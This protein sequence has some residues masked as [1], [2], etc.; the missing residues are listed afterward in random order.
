MTAAPIL[1]ATDLSARADRAI[2]RA[3]MLGQQLDRN[4]AVVYAQK[5]NDHHGEV[6]VENLVRAVLPQP[7]AD[8]RILSPTGTPPEEI[9]QAAKDTGAAIL[10]VGPARHNS[11]GDFFLGTAVDYIARFSDVPLLV[12]KK[13]AHN[14]Y[15]KI[16]FASDFS[17]CSRDALMIAA[18]LFP[19]TEIR[20]VH[21]YQVPFQSWQKA[22]YVREEVRN[23]AQEN[24]DG[25]IDSLSRIP[26]LAGRVTGAIVYGR[27][28]QAISA[29]AEKSTSIL[30][31][32]GTHGESGFRHATIGSVANQLLDTLPIDCLMIK[33]AQG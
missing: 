19:K 1:V 12:V 28:F 15:D 25:F 30:A 18:K 3:M 7:Q 29:E 2:D 22:T 13:R 33:S 31:A 32:F 9:A 14:Y 11:I 20:I 10:C 4:V 5:F 26:E 27:A 21:A 16:I 24:M 23:W 17:D 6:D 8:V